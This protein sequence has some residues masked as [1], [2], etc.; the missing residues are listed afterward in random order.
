MASAESRRWKLDWHN[1]GRTAIRPREFLCKRVVCV[2][3]GGGSGNTFN[4]MIWGYERSVTAEPSASALEESLIS[5]PPVQM[6]WVGGQ[7]WGVRDSSG[8][9]EEGTRS[10]AW[11]RLGHICLGYKET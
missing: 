2:W 7:V 1:L 3:G 4:L 8:R 5:L 10:P 6:F 11:R 9:L